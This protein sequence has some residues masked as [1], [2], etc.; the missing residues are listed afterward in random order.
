MTDQ[1]FTLTELMTVAAAREIKDGEVVFAGTGL[2][3]LGVML[4]QRT[5]APNC[6]IIFE[7]GTM[8]SHLR[9][10]PMSVGDPRTLH[11]A[12]SAAGLMEVFAYALQAGRVDVRALGRAVGTG[13][14][15]YVQDYIRFP[16]FLESGAKCFDK[17][18]GQIR[19][20]AHGIRQD[21]GSTAW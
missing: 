19:D 10:L 13:D 12:A 18:M 1:F 5:H 21:R 7:A 6:C 2:P 4:A 17:F 15:S 3:M 11:G 8:A 14:V 20:K 16:H 9:H